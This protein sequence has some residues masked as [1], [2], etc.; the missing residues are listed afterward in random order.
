MKEEGPVTLVTGAFGQVGKLCTEILLR[1]GHTV[2]AMDLRN[3]SA[4]A[5]AAI[6]SES[7]CRA[8]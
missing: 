1:R 5:A 8:R 2:V 6:L 7:R 4:V 3:G